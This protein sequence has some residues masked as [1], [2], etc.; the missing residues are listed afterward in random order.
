MPR[1]SVRAY[2]IMSRKKEKIYKRWDEVTRKEV[3]DDQFEKMGRDVH[4]GAKSPV[5]IR[6]V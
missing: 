2:G 1:M 6:V 4:F 3:R 5:R